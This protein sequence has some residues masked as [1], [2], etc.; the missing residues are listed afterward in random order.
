VTC[1]LFKADSDCVH[2]NDYL[3]TSNED[4]IPFDAGMVEQIHR[5]FK[6]PEEMH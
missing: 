4:A 5:L 6:S 2:Q 3:F 1:R